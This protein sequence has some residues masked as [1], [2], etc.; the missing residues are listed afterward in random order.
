M[1]LICVAILIVT[2][3]FI[4]PKV[5][6]KIKVPI[7]I[8]LIVVILGTLSSKFLN[9]NTNHTVKIVGYIAKGL[10]TPALPDLSNMSSFISDIFIT[11]I[12]AFS[13]CVSLAKIFSKKNGYSIDANQV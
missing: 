11:A 13:I 2:K 8:E 1:T 6:S 12:I 5:E 7:P 4:N 10:P 9:L 3:E